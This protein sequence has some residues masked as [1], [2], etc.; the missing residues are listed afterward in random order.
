MRRQTAIWEETVEAL[1]RE[2]VPVAIQDDNV[3][4][5]MSEVGDMTVSFIQLK[6]GADLGPALVGLPDDLCPCPHWGYMLNGRLKMRTKD[7]DKF[8]EGGQAFYWAPGH[9]PVAETDCE[10]VDFSP[11]EEFAKV[12]RHISG[13]G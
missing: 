5:R 9:A 1:N 7:G 2:D 13:Q 3:E 10:Y 11:T 12:I 4:L 6:E 8:Y